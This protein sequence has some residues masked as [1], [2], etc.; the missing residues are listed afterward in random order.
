MS[1]EFT[2]RVYAHRQERAAAHLPSVDP[3]PVIQLYN[4]ILA[5]IADKVS[6]E[7]LSR[8]SWP[9]GEFCL[10]ESRDFVPHQGWNSDQHL[11]WLHKAIL[12]LQLPLWEQQSA[13]GGQ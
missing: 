10:P 6:S 13:T 2:P 8:L 4:S 7:E 5:H 11:A 3:A 1:R 12:S 9:P